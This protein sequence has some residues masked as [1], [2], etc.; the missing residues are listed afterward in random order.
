[1][2]VTKF[3]AISLLVCNS[4]FGQEINFSEVSFASWD[5]EM[6]REKLFELFEDEPPSDEKLTSLLNKLVSVDAF[7]VNIRSKNGKESL[8]D[9]CVNNGLYSSASVLVNNGYKINQRCFA[10]NG[11]TPMHVALKRSKK[12]EDTPS[13]L[14][15]LMALMF[16]KGAN[17]D[18]RDMKG[19]SVVHVIFENND[20]ESF[21]LLMQEDIT[22]NYQL[23]TL[24]GVGYLLHFDK[25]WGD[26]DLREQLM[27]KTGL[28]YPPTK[29]DIR[30]KAKDAKEKAKEEKSA[31]K[32][33]K[34]A[35]KEN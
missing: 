29:E 22:F 25:A 27:E 31:K 9:A 16:E 20:Y 17:A 14:I 18:L 7:D 8:F 11:E 4:V 26:D 23:T 3:L 10:C 5:K 13:E 12:V 28:K 15:D 35:K 1:M 30:N 34:K 19:R 6:Q 24:K 21:G 32:E 2:R 33:K